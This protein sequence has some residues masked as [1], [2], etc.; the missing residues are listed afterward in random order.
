[1]QQYRS[2]TYADSD[3]LNFKD[4]KLEQEAQ[5]AHAQR[6]NQ[7]D[8]LRQKLENGEISEAEYNTLSAQGEFKSS[9]TEL[10]LPSYIPS[11]Y[12]VDE[13]A[14]TDSLSE[15]DIQYLMLK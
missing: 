2:Y 12:R 6:Q 10:E 15:D 3:K 4:E 5:A 11:S 13:S 7:E 8:E 14:I 1:M 9:T